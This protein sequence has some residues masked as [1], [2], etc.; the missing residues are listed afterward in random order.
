[1]KE[2]GRLT[3]WLSTLFVIIGWSAAIG[4]VHLFFAR[5]RIPDAGLALAL[6]VAI[7]QAVCIVVMLTALMAKKAVRARRE[8]RSAELR[9][10]IAGNLASDVVA[11][12][13]RVRALRGYLAASRR[14]VEREIAA[15]AATLRGSSRERILELGREFG[16]TSPEPEGRLE[17]VFAKAAG[18]NLLERA[19]AAEEL[20]PHAQRL[21][22]V[23][24]PRALRSDDSSRVLAALEMLH[25][26]KRSL[27]VPEVAM[28][29][30][31]GDPRVRAAAL[32]ALPYSA[33]GGYETNV[34]HALRD[35]DP[36]VRRAAAETARKLRLEA[37]LDGLVENLNDR[38]RSAALAAAFAVAVMPE[39]MGRLERVVAS[40]D[41]FAAAVAFEALEKATIGR[42]HF[43]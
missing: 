31:H 13:D 16:I 27:P 24:I 37:L 22:E 43:S 2:G 10:R 19:V 15:M 1:M 12:R 9:L 5:T 26:W 20:E 33:P 14:D 17:E 35:S 32:R 41:R 21:A 4:A 25:A 34:G 30:R 38:D 28:V 36:E 39:G 40:D 23:Q 42:L 7:V 18:G 6:S 8:A 3:I 29:L 11:G